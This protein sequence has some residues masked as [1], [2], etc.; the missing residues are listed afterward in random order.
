MFRIPV[1]PIMA[2]LADIQDMLYIPDIS[3]TGVSYIDLNGRNPSKFLLIKIFNEWQYDLYT[4]QIGHYS[5]HRYMIHIF[6]VLVFD[7]YN[8]RF[9]RYSKHVSLTGRFIYRC[10]P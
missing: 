5:K 10:F 2:V 1:I 3:Y 6:H 8:G 7:K 9:G 4:G